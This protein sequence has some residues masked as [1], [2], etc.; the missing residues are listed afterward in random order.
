MVE[1]KL[2]VILKALR[3]LSSLDKVLGRGAGRDSRKSW[4]LTC[5]DL[6]HLTSCPYSQGCSQCHTDH[7]DP[8]PLLPRT[9]LPGHREWHRVCGAATRLPH[10]RRQDHQLRRSAAMVSS[11]SVPRMGRGLLQVAPARALV[12]HFYPRKSKGPRRK[13][14]NFLP[15]SQTDYLS[16]S[17]C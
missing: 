15:T 9:A 16:T 14:L 17:V 10:A 1:C 7:R 4:G 2:M 12:Y 8:S 11:S 13:P 3:G 6:R 5:P